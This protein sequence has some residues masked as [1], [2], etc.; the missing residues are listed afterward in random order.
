MPPKS[1]GLGI[2]KTNIAQSFEIQQSEQPCVNRFHVTL[3]SYKRYLKC[4]N[5]ILWADE[6][7]NDVTKLSMTDFH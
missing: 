7:S 1:Y 3:H 4:I 2:K 6:S 5:L